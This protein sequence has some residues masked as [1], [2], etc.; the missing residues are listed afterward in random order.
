MLP[1]LHVDHNRM[2]HFELRTES[3]H[4]ARRVRVRRARCHSGNLERTHQSI[5]PSSIKRG[6]KDVVHAINP[7]HRAWCTRGDWPGIRASRL[8]R[9]L[10]TRMRSWRQGFARSPQ[11]CCSIHR[12]QL[13]GFRPVSCLFCGTRRPRALASFT[14]LAPFVR[15]DALVISSPK[16]PG[17]AC[18]ARVAGS[19][20]RG[21]V[22]VVL[23][24]I[25]YLASTGLP[26][27]PAGLCTTGIGY[28]EGNMQQ[29]MTYWPARVTRWLLLSIPVSGGE[30]RAQEKSGLVTIR[31]KSGRYSVVASLQVPDKYPLEGCGVELRS[32]NFP[33][34]I[35]RLHLA[36]VPWVV[37]RGY[38]PRVDL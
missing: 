5:F 13:P 3:M 33:E 6:A 15:R 12:T 1:G 23:R 10:E 38:L 31:V 24:A 35:A 37:L 11:V 9:M 29:P 20:A 28:R 27:V 16:F 8:D 7:A 22:V 21:D 32:H 26:S 36:Q 19:T 18:R 30:C 25:N 14:S 2:M 17:A 34:R 4:A